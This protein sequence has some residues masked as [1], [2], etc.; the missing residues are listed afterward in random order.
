MLIN[1]D[2]ANCRCPGK[3]HQANEMSLSVPMPRLKRKTM[4]RSG[5]VVHDKAERKER[6]YI[7]NGHTG[8]NGLL[9]VFSQL[10]CRKE[11]NSGDVKESKS[12]NKGESKWNRSNSSG[13]NVMNWINHEKRSQ[14]EYMNNND[15][16]NSNTANSNNA[17]VGVQRKVSFDKTYFSSKLNNFSYKLFG[18]GDNHSNNSNNNNVNIPISPKH[19]HPSKRQLDSFYSKWY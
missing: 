13:V 18:G 9:K 4:T 8:K 15:N 1:K 6:F 10:N 11:R 12:G 5:S 14:R 7:L 19:H 17:N 2:D 3:N 16:G